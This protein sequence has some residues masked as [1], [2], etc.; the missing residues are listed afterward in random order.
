[1]WHDKLTFDDQRPS[2]DLTAI[3]FAVEGLGEFL[4]SEG[5]GILEFDIEQGSRW[6]TD[7]GVSN[8]SYINQKKGI[9][10]EFSDYLNSKIAI[11]PKMSGKI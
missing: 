8:Q 7:V 6:S 10:K 3:Y 2:W 4:T 5:K 11:P 9:A 1:L